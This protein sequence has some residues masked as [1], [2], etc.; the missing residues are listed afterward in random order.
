M[1]AFFK[2]LSFDHLKINGDP[3]I[4]LI[5]FLLGLVLLLVGRQVSKYQ[6]KSLK[7]GKNE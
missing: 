1:D 5:L 6:K 4:G 7:K 3:I 2:G